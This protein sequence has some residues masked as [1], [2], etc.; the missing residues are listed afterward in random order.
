MKSTPRWARLM[1]P[2]TANRGP[3]PTTLASDAVWCGSAY[4]GRRIRPPSS[5]RPASEWIADTSSASL[6]SRS[7]RLPGRRALSMVVRRV[8]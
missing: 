5:G 4:G 8:S 1:L 6:W 7:G 3:P 2:G